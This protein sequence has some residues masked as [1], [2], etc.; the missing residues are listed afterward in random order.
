MSHLDS[1][2]ASHEVRLAR[3]LFP[4]LAQQLDRAL[5]RGT[6]ETVGGERSVR[7]RLDRAAQE[8]KAGLLGRAAYEGVPANEAERLERAFVSAETVASWTGVT[9]PEPEAFW[10]AGVDRV[11]LARALAQDSTLMPVIAPYGLGVPGWREWYLAAVVHGDGVLDSGGGLSLAP[12]VI[13]SFSELDAAP[14]SVPLVHGRG[15]A[16]W[17]LRLIPAAVE[18]ERTHGNHGLGPHPTLPE[19]LMLQLVR[20]AEGLP[21]VDSQSFTWLHGTLL[22]GRFAARHFYDAVAHHVGVNSREVGSQGP[23]LGARPPVG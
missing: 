18:P 17:T 3:H 6:G 13:A 2:G 1:S 9:V 7:A 11:V 10:A 4:E 21:L 15:V 12:E 16:Q 22:D 14:Q 20:V 23:H 19:M 5:E 8:A